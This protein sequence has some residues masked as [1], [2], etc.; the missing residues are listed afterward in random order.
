M[1]LMGFADEAADS[2]EGQIEVIQELGW[3]AL[4]IR[5]VDGENVHDL[6]EEKFESVRRLLESS[7]LH[8]YG[9]GSNIANWGS[10]PDS[11]HK[12][13]MEAV[14]R[15]VA[16]MKV[17]GS[18]C[19]RIMS[20]KLLL[21][22]QG[23]A[24]ANQMEN[25]R[26]R[27]LRE[28]VEAFVD[29]GL[30]PVHENCATWGGMSWGHSLELVEKIP[31][32]KLVFDTGNPPLTDDYSKDWPYPA[33]SSWEF[34]THVKHHVAHIHIKDSRKDADTGEEIFC[35]PGEGEGDVERILDDVKAIGYNA[36]MSIEPH[37]AVVYHDSAV[38]ASSHVRRDNFIRYGRK[39]EEM[40]RIRGFSLE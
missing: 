29:S 15:A 7:G 2:I 9:M 26:I 31:G 25:E 4:E 16:R 27:R 35:W 32:L 19:V 12:D 10:S 28:I 11:S 34:W 24:L 36:G 23:R 6:S 22:E 3:K 33:Q 5:A 38:K 39:L 1:K 17:L 13:T 21:D 20:Y 14:R 40:L 18:Q 37:M 30:T 8:A